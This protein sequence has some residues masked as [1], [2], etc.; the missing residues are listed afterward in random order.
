MP[1]NTSMES[2]RKDWHDVQECA[3]NH[4]IHRVLYFHDF[5]R[6]YF[7]HAR[8]V[9]A[10]VSGEMEDGDQTMLDCV[11]DG[12]RSNCTCRRRDFLCKYYCTIKLPP[13]LSAL[14]ELVRRL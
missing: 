10:W 1:K 7:A 3:T 8:S 5:E 2:D 11:R 12:G 6:I 9:D 13:L 4:S 14:D